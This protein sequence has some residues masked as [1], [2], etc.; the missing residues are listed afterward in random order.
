MLG[1]N[2]ANYRRKLGL[3]QEQLAQRLD[4]TNQ[5]VSKWETDQCCPATLL[6]PKIADIFEITIDELFGRTPAKHAQEEPEQPTELPWADD[7]A[8]HVVLYHGDTLIGA[9][10]EHADLTFEYEGPAKDVYCT[11]NLNCGDVEGNVTTDGNVECGDVGGV[12]NA[13]GYVECGDISGCLNAG[14]YVECGDVSGSVSAGS[15]VECSDVEG[16]VNSA[17]YV[18]CGDVGGDVKAMS[19]VE[20]GDVGGSASSDG[21][22]VQSGEGKGFRFGKT[23]RFGKK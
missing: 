2:I 9:Q 11:L 14:G 8:F 3:T 6:L 13:G 17:S 20:C 4:V 18:E 15:Y 19:Y 1:M 21:G 10:S 12:V 5:A 7:D 23:F 16:D 22:S